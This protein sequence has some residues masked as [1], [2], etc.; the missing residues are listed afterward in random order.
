MASLR[1]RAA[2]VQELLLSEWQDTGESISIIKA[3]GRVNLI[4]E[5]TDYNDGFV[6]PVAIDRDIIMAARPRDDGQV[7]AYAAD[8]DAKSSFHLDDIQHDSDAPWSNY[9]RGMFLLLKQRGFA[10]KG[11]DAAFSGNVPLAAGLSSSAALEMSTGLAAS[12]I[13]GFHIDKVELAE[14]GQ[15]TENDFVGVNCGIM[16]QFI[17]ALGEKGRAL[18]LDCRSLEYELISLPFMEEYKI[19]IGN[20]MV[21][22]GL[23]DS[24]Y[25]ERRSQCEEGVRI[26]KQHLPRITALRDVSTAEFQKYR[27]HLPSI[28]AKR[29]EHVIREN[30]RVL[31]SVEALKSGNH[32]VFGE[33]M[34]A[35][36]ESLKDLYE[37]SCRELDIM[38]EAA[39]GLSETIGSRMTGAGFGGCTVSL[40]QAAQVDNFI[41]TV[42]A[43]YQSK[44]GLEPEFYVCSAE[45]GAVQLEL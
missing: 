4:G 45:D 37:V 9:I 8:L 38:V 25:N 35:S 6:L 43:T 32:L 44:T 19:V 26:L 14:I 31:D 21:Q 12:V 15:A 39:L 10:V 13:G 20:T 22:R 29:C 23:V 3:P 33:L 34:Q 11:M 7:N 17:S 28:V 40:V 16:D 30:Q 2:R 42:H 24:A 27:S 36:H 1:E 18:F 41:D 5:H